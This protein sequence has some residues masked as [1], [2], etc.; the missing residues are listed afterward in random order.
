M[1]ATLRPRAVGRY[2]PLSLGRQLRPS[3]ARFFEIFDFIAPAIMEKFYDREKVQT[4]I[5]MLN[6]LRRG[7]SYAEREEWARLTV[8]KVER[9]F[10][11]QKK[12]AEFPEIGT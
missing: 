2:R 5:K 3:R 11:A 12:I 8:E 6:A 4:A 1:Q 10:E 7:I 9:V